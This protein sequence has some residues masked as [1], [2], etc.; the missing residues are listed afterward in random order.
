MTNQNALPTSLPAELA[1]KVSVF[2]SEHG[3]LVNPTSPLTPFGEGGL[4]YSSNAMPIINALLS[5]IKTLEMQIVSIGSEARKI[6]A[7]HLR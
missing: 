4:C 3:F 1:R 6:N 2:R 5:H 7:E